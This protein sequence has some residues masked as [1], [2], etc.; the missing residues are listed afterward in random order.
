MEL[1]GERA[2]VYHARGPGFD[3][4]HY[5]KI[6]INTNNLNNVLKIS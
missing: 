4:Y 1:R 2:S 3:Y 5:T 6:K